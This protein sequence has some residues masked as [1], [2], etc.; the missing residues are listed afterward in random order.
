MRAA[1]ASSDAVA[2]TS[3]VT[4]AQLE[5]DVLPAV[6]HVSVRSSRTIASR[7]F[8]SVAARSGLVALF[9]MTTSLVVVALSRF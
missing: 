8:R 9:A 6:D 5:G 2:L 4:P 1:Q 3:V 7:R